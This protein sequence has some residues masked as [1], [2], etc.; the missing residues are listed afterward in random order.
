MA[1]LGSYP[2][3]LTRDEVLAILTGPEDMSAL[4]SPLKEVIRNGQNAEAIYEAFQAV[5]TDEE[6]AEEEAWNRLLCCAIEFQH[7]GLIDLLLN[8]GHAYNH[9]GVNLLLYIQLNHSEM[10]Y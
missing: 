3:V 1:A 6:S 10:L 8:K 7:E 4:S 5:I 9:V 2:D